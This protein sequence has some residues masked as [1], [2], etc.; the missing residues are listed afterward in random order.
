MATCLGL[1][2]VWPEINKLKNQIVEEKS[3]NNITMV[4]FMLRV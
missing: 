4:D 1:V 3:R 2:D